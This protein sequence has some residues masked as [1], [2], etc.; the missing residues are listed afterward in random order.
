MMKFSIVIPARNE[1]S[2]LARTLKS[3]ENQDYSNYETIVVA[4]ACNDNTA[5]VAEMYADKVFVINDPGVS[6]ARNLGAKW[7]SGDVLIFLDADTRLGPGVLKKIGKNFRKRHAVGTVRV[8]PN[9]P[10][11]LYKGMMAFK[12]LIG[13]LGIYPW[14]CGIIYCRKNDFIGFDEKLNVKETI[15]FVRRM[16]RRKGNFYFLDNGYVTTS[17]RRYEK[18]GSFGLVWFFIRKWFKSFFSNVEGDRY[19]VIR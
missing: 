1:E 15:Y 19:P 13:G 14:T 6:R 10:K 8:R 2:Y 7:A 16:I 17:M 12:N 9:A 5:A 11:L 18:W 3:I 4:N